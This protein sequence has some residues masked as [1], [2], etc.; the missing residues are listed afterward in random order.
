MLNENQFCDTRHFCTIVVLSI[1]KNCL[2]PKQKA[3]PGSKESLRSIYAR[4]GGV[5]AHLISI[6]MMLYVFIKEIYFTFLNTHLF[7]Y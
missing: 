4:F 2:C 5:S 7:Y 1:A 6:N 3:S